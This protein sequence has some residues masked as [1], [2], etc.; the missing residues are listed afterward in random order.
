[1]ATSIISL[2]LLPFIIQPVELSNSN[3]RVSFTVDSTWHLVE[4]EAK[5]LSGLISFGESASQSTSEVKVL[6]PARN[7]DTDSSL[8]DEKMREVLDIEHFPEIKFIGGPLGPGCNLAELKESEQ[9]RTSLPGKVT[10]R[11]V[12]LPIELVVDGVLADGKIKFHGEAN[13]D[14]SKFNV[15]D[16]SILVA[17]LD[18]LV[19][20]FI[21]VEFDVRH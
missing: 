14:W 13:L 17:R 6:I 19:R 10:I 7:L 5:S 18:K 20:L 21:D 2:L 1:M 11:D 16:P 4:G 15:E 9:C 3:T 8:R 12:T